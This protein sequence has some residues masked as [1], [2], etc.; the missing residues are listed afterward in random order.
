[1]KQRYTIQRA[2]GGEE[3]EDE[4]V[5]DGGDVFVALLAEVTGCSGCRGFEWIDE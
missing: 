5:G 3:G 1:M 4:F 2:V